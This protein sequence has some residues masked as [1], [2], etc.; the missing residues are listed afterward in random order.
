MAPVPPSPIK[1]ALLNC[2][3]LSLI[4]SKLFDNKCDFQIRIGQFYGAFLFGF[5]LIN[6]INE[7]NTVTH[8]NLFAFY[9]L[10]L[11]SIYLDE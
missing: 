5:I 6:G 2:G 7:S 1:R 4:A 9:R 10:S 11:T 3:F 8:L